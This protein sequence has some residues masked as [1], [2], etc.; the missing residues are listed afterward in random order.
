MGSFRTVRRRYLL[1]ALLLVT[2]IGC[3]QATKQIATRTLKNAPP[4]SYCA[5]T[6]QLHYALNPGGFLSLGSRLSDRARWWIFVGLNTVLVL[7]LCAYLFVNR[8][9]SFAAFLSFVFILAG[10]IGNQIDRLWNNGLVTDFLVLSAGPVRTGV[11]NVAD[12]A[13]TFGTISVVLLSFRK[14]PEDVAEPEAV[15]NGTC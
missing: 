6:V 1:A 15:P 10:S 3:D 2:C 12:V 11:F 4:R 5:N 8:H 9:V 13:V 14:P 7:G